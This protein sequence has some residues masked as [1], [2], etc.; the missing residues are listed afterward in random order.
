MAVPAN[1]WGSAVYTTAQLK[2]IREIV[3]L[4]VFAGFDALFEGADDVE[5]RDRF[6]AGG[7]RRVL[8][9]SRTV[10][11]INVTARRTPQA[12][13]LFMHCNILTKAVASASTSAH[14]LV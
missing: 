10:T 7:G 8:H 13:D 2:T 9:L 4:L 14:Y 6:C 12:V 3:T 5:L 11:S 1:R